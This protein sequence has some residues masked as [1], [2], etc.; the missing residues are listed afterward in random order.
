MI[1]LFYHVHSTARALPAPVH[2]A[3][4]VI[5]HSVKPFSNQYN[6]H[7]CARLTSRPSHASIQPRNCPEPA[8][9][10]LRLSPGRNG[11]LRQQALHLYVKVSCSQ[12]AIQVKASSRNDKNFAPTSLAWD[13]LPMW[14]AGQ[15]SCAGALTHPQS[16]GVDTLCAATSQHWNTS[17]AKKK[18]NSNWGELEPRETF[19]NQCQEKKQETSETHHNRTII[20]D[21]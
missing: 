7:I 16:E 1:H 19:V 2:L 17:I 4:L 21:S 20:I 12:Q 14:S 15:R 11:S 3:E 10:L 8:S 9:H 18:S 5:L 13:I 6:R